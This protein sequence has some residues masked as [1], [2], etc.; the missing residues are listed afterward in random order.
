MTQN[1]S[2][3]QVSR[4]FDKV[5][6]IYPDVAEEAS[7]DGNVAVTTAATLSHV[8]HGVSPQT[9]FDSIYHEHYTDETRQFESVG[10]RDYEHNVVSTI[11]SSIK[12][13]RKRIDYAS[14]KNTPVFV[15]ISDAFS[16]IF[17]LDWND[18]R[19]ANGL[20]SDIVSMYWEMSELFD[21]LALDYSKSTVVIGP[22]NHIHNQI[23]VFEALCG[24]SKL[25]IKK[26][27]DYY[28]E[29]NSRPHQD[30]LEKLAK[31]AQMS[32]VKYDSA[33]RFDSKEDY[34][35]SQLGDKAGE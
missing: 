20:P 32:I 18:P 23:G 15:T 31:L 26:D 30:T 6:A 35:R 33:S 29:Y 17:A 12:D 27:K 34:L 10:Y 1:K 14:K 19:I 25:D 3:H 7:R 8:D 5:F 22:L 11:P 2:E 28:F 9:V 24:D 16:S 4:K 13:A 21:S